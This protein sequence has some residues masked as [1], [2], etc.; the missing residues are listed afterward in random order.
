[1]SFL[2]KTKWS[3]HTEA[4]H[5]AVVD[6]V[7]KTETLTKIATSKRLIRNKKAW[8]RNEEITKINQGL[9]VKE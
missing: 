4:I 6:L 3:T 2:K 7:V 9:E 5:I 1:M 8:I